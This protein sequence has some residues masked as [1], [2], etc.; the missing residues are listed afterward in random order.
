MTDWH[1]AEQ[2]HG[3]NNPSTYYEW[4]ESEDPR[5]LVV[6]ERDNW[7]QLDELF[8]GD[9]I[10]PIYYREYRRDGRLEHIGG[11]DDDVV[12]AAWIDAYGRTPYRRVEHAY[13]GT[14]FKA[15]VDPVI[16]ADRF[17]RIF[18][19]AQVEHTSGGYR[20]DGEYLV[21]DTPE[22]RRHIGDDPANVSAETV[23]SVGSELAKALDGDVYGIGWASNEARRLPGDDEIDLTDGTWE[24]TIECWGFIGDEYAKEEALGLGFGGP[25]LPEMLALEEVTA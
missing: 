4:A 8:D 16:F 20:P 6:I 12:A 22:Y 21:F 13:Y 7:A 10:N 23:E 18:H 15:V 3:C 24:I 25:K 17:V 11:W 19:G 2:S 14:Q 1:D 9:A 5:V